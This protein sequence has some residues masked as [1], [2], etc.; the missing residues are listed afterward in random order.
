MVRNSELPP[1]GGFASLFAQVVKEAIDA[2]G[3]SGSELGRRLGRA[4]SYASLRLNGRRAWDLYEVDAI[5]DMLG[6][7]TDELIDRARGLR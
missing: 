4:Q 6:V 3:I 5:A 1:L 2:A 7:S